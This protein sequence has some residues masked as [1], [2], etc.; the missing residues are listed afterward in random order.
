[1]SSR[2]KRTISCGRDNICEIFECSM[3]YSVPP[4]ACRIKCVAPF[5]SIGFFFKPSLWV[6]N[7]DN[8]TI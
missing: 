3:P 7:L 2:N 1:M 8:E 4:K 6:K 5:L